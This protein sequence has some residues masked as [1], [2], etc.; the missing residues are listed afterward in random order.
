MQHRRQNRI[1]TLITELHSNEDKVTLLKTKHTKAK[2]DIRVAKACMSKIQLKLDKAARKYRAKVKTFQLLD[3]ILAEFKFA[4]KQ[5]AEL[6]AIKTKKASNR[7]VKTAAEAIKDA[8]AC[9]DSLPE[10]Q[11][12]AVIAAMKTTAQE[13]D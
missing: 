1:N 11:R 9:L 13:E 5:K 6:E 7:K 3:K 10:A 8:M 2:E 4:T 12:Q